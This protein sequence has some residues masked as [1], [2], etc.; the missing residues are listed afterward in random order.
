D[1][2]EQAPPHEPGGDHHGN[3][4]PVEHDVELGHEVVEPLVYEANLDLPVAERLEHVVNLVRRLA[5]DLGERTR[6]PP[7]PRGHAARRVA[8]QHQ[9]A[10]I[11]SRHVE[12][13]EVGVQL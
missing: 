1:G 7:C 13:V 6:L 11:G 5:H 2:R 10:R 3:D 12:H 9:V 4:E 8:L